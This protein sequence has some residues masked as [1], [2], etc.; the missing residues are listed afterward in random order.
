MYKVMLVD[1][2]YMILEGLK[3][4]LPWQDLGFEIV[5]TARNAKEALS[6]FED[7]EIDLLITDINMPEISGIQLIETA[8]NEGRHFLSLILSGY[9]EFEYVKRGIDLGVK[10][11][12]LKPVDKEELLRSVKQIK[13]LLD[14]EKQFDRQQQLFLENNLVRWL[15]DELNDSEFIEMLQHFHLEA[16]PPYT[17]VLLEGDSSRLQ[18]A[19]DFLRG[20]GQ[21]L[22]I[23]GWIHQSGQL[24]WLYMGT[25]QS[26]YVLLHY[27]ERLTIDQLRFV[28]GE[29]VAEW[30]NVYESYERVQ[31]IRRL[32]EFYPELLPE[33]LSSSDFIQEPDYDMSFLSFNKALMI[34]DEKTVRGEL[35]RIFRELMVK[36]YSPEY[37]RYVAFL[38]FADISRQ[39]PTAT[40]EIYDETVV[41]IRKSHTIDEIKKM[42]TAVLD[43]VRNTDRPAVYSDAVSQV[44]AMVD[45]DYREELNLKTIAEALHLNVVYLGQLFKKETNRSFSQYLNQIR[46]KKAQQLLLHSTQTISEIA[47]AIGYNNT[48]YFSKMF[49]KLNGITPKEF[50]DQ[51]DSGYEALE[52]KDN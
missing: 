3:Q 36:H 25:R 32:R 17:A 12:L 46:I 5:K 38:L 4:I 33:L 1:D 28:V 47:D 39:F 11:Y 15:N 44:I 14:E 50:R 10:N 40:Q 49:K 48:N 30:E 19:A 21:K 43:N 13:L 20:Q 23:E 41:G 29:T 9:Q 52:G 16:Q 42:L 45:D 34:G 24:L 27:L 26:L 31:Q 18:E 37:V 7:H 6:F 35:D 2:E 51:Y 22:L 8:Q